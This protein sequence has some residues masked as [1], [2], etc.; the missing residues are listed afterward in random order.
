MT[1]H[2]VP[3]TYKPKIEPVRNGSCTQTIRTLK[4]RPKR[5]GD[6]LRIYTWTGKPYRSPQEVL[7]WGRVT[8]AIDIKLYPSGFELFTLASEGVFAVSAYR[9]TDRF[10]DALAL[11]DGIDPPTGTELGRVLSLKNRIS[12]NGENGQIIRWEVI[13]HEI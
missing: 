1:T 11:R 5:V 8:E 6:I 4:K 12:P 10:A 9:W 7:C 13:K 3:V 2:N